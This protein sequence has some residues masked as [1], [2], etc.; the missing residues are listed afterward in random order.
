MLK[1]F[2]IICFISFLSLFGEILLYF[3]KNAMDIG[4]KSIKENQTKVVSKTFQN[5]DI[6]EIN[7]KYK[8]IS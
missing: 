7:K 6:Y 2:D 3:C 4:Q 5:A 1:I 8:K